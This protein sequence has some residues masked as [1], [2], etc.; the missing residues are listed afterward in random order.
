AA[1]RITRVIGPGPLQ[2]GDVGRRDLGQGGEFRAARIM[3]DNGPV[4]GIRRAKRLRGEKQ[5]R[6]GGS[7]E[8]D[9]GDAVHDSFPS[10]QISPAGPSTARSVS[11]SCFIAPRTCSR[12]SVILSRPLPAPPLAYSAWTSTGPWKLI[13]FMTCATAG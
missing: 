8:S 9:L 11:R 4:T 6:R 1:R 2:A 3:A 7:A 13:S 5:C 12:G 10:P